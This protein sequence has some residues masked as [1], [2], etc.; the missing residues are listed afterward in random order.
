MIVLDT[1]PI[2]LIR[3]RTHLSGSEIDG[4]NKL[5]KR[6]KGSL[7]SSYDW[8]KAWANSI[9][10]WKKIIVALGYHN[11][12]LTFVLPLVIQKLL[13]VSLAYSPNRKFL[14]QSCILSQ[15]DMLLPF[16][17]DQVKASIKNFILYEVSEPLKEKLSHLE[18]PTLIEHSSTSFSLEIQ[19]LWPY[20]NF[21]K[22]SFKELLRLQKQVNFQLKILSSSEVNPTHIFEFETISSKFWTSKTVF[23]QI[24]HQKF[25]TEIIKNPYIKVHLLTKGNEIIALDLWGSL[26]GEAFSLYRAYLPKYHK[27]SPWNI[28]QH[29]QIQEIIKDKHSSYHLYRGYTNQKKRFAN[30]QYEQYNLYF[31]SNP[32]LKSYFNI[33]LYI[34]TQYLALKSFIKKQLKKFWFI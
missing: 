3:K 25:F 27:Y 6:E 32:L 15:S 24:K 18:S 34:K 16:F 23:Q 4:W 33:K 10:Q 12:K 1:K 8:V 26:H 20:Y 2:L 11:N 13:F 17:I 14:D 28:L 31:F 22:K 7:F 19:R 9:E 5:R 30:T 29:K 21:S